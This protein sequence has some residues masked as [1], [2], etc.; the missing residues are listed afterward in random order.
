VSPKCCEPAG[1]NCID[2]DLCC[3][4]FH[5]LCTGLSAESYKVLFS[6]VSE[7]GWVCADCRRNDSNTISKLKSSL[8]REVVPKDDC[9][10]FDGIKVTMDI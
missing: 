9:R 7:C 1:K 8:S 5:P 6:I 2:C 3:D 10:N 4:T